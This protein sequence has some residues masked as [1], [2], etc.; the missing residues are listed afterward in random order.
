MK[1]SLAVCLVG[2]AA[3]CAALAIVGVPSRLRA[4]E[5]SFVQI[6]RGKELVAAGDCEG[7]H[8]VQ[9]GAKF[10]GGRP[11]QTPFGTIYTSNI[12]SDA[13]TGIGS[14]TEDQFYRAM[15]EGIDNKGNHLYP[16]FPY[17]WFT[18]V[19]RQDVEA[20]H[21]YL[22][23]LPAVRYR[24]PGNT[25]PWP[26]DQRATMAGWNTFY[27]KPGTYEPDPNRS[28]QWNRGAYLVFGLGHCG[29]CHTP[30]NFLGAA[31]ADRHLQGG[32]LSDWFAPSLVGDR[33]DGLGNW[34]EQQIVNFLKTGQTKDGV[35]Y[36][37]MEEV[38]HY[39]T[40]AM[41]DDDLKAIAVYLKSLPAA[42]GP[43]AASRPA[44]DIANAGQAIYVDSCSA[45]H[46]ENGQGVAELF[47]ALKASAI[48]Q[49][50][51]PTTV[52]RLILNGGHAVATDQR[53]TG[54]SMPSFG[55][56]LSDAEVAALASYI[57]SA[58]GNEAAPVSASDVQ[59][60]RKAV[61]N[62]SS[63]D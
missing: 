57:R 30:D 34:T 58:W 42:K 56:K 5:S 19:T 21:A 62:A 55:W 33:R 16:A 41:S 47:P 14:W 20:I 4:E 38:V 46:G 27:F 2:S 12:T 43:A 15:H 18:K 37:P 52:I 7:C 1:K 32:V 9:G 25:L 49:G 63:A 54:V 3:A 31:K 39:S 60:E 40:S 44:S 51:N 11:L 24:R 26:L 22:G 45:C 8:T 53:P 23:T 35:A 59:D 6:Q 13:E 48:V 17:P 50:E 10:A 36:G 61:E 29:A 28:T